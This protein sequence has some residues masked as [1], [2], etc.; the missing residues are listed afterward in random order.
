MKMVKNTCF[1]RL[2]A[3]VS[4]AATLSFSATVSGGKIKRVEVGPAGYFSVLLE[5]DGTTASATCAANQWY[6]LY[7]ADLSDAGSYQAILSLVL[8]AYSIGVPVTLYSGSSSCN[9]NKF[10]W[11]ATK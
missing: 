6:Y 2:F 4:M 8:S 9:S 1:F 7:K 5:D 11:V 10:T 3:F